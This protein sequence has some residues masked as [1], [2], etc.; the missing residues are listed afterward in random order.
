MDSKQQ[1]SLVKHERSIRFSVRVAVLLRRERWQA[2][3]IW[4]VLGASIGGLVLY[5]VFHDLGWNQLVAWNPDLAASRPWRDATA[6]AAR[7]GPW[8]PILIAATPLPQTPALAIATGPRLLVLEVLVALL[9]GK[10]SKNGAYAWWVT[11]FPERFTR[12]LRFNS[13]VRL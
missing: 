3:A 11:R 7:Y 9:V 12:Y 10:L 1:F 5:L 4:S 6:W 2:I 13:F 8:A